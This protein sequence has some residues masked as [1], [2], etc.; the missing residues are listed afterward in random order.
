MKKHKFD[1]RLVEAD[2]RKNLASELLSLTM[3]LEE[4][5]RLESILYASTMLSDDA[6][7]LIYDYM[8]D[9]DDVDIGVGALMK[10]SNKTGKTLDEIL[11]F[12]QE[13][14]KYNGKNKINKE[15]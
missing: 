14:R 7:K 5:K 4:C 8:D 3:E 11:D 6:N 12:F 1:N 13:V 10:I 2:I 9:P 15:I